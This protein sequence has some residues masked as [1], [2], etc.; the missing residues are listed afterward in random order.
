MLSFLKRLF[1]KSNS[2]TQDKFATQDKRVLPAA[3]STPTGISYKPELIGNLKSDHVE[4]LKLFGSLVEHH[5]S[6]NFDQCVTALQKFTHALR[7]HLL[8]ENLHLYVYLKYAVQD[9]PES[10]ALLSAMRTEMQQI[11][12]ALN[13]FVTVYTSSP[14]TSASREQLGKD[15]GGIAQI[16]TRRI[17]EEE[18]TLYP[19]YMP[20]SSYA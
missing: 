18:R 7:T 2:A 15:L 4:L 8:Q 16:L 19:L 20:P 14:W 9:D 11:G 5:G 3:T 6:G 13:E 12:R 10:S 1:G 17:K